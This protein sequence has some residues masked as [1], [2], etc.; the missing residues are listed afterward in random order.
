[1]LCSKSTGDDVW[2]QR[3]DFIIYR[4]VCVLSPEWNVKNEDNEQ[5]SRNGHT[6]VGWRAAHY[7]EKGRSWIY[8]C[9]DAGADGRQFVS[10]LFSVIYGKMDPQ[11]PRKDQV[12]H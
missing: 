9:L 10:V 6:V 3:V 1:M 11:C 2:W 4:T 8:A 7:T 12:I 5:Y